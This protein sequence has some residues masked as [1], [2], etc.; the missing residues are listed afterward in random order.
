MTPA[1]PTRRTA[2]LASASSLLLAACGKGSGSDTGNSTVRA[3]N[4][5]NDLTSLDLYLGGAKAFGNVGIG[6][7]ASYGTFTAG[8]NTLNVNSTGNTTTLFTGSYTLS[9][10]AHYTA[11]V[12]GPQSSLRVS[13]LPEDE[14]TTAIASGNTR[15]R[16]FN[17]TTETGS[18]DVYFTA[19]DADLGASTPTQGALTTGALAGFK[20]IPSGTYRLRVTGVGNP[21]DVRLDIAAVTLAAGQ[22]QTLVI[23]A[24][25]GGVLV[26][27]TLI[28]QQGNATAL[29]NTKAR[30]RV[31]ASVDSAGVVAATVGGTVLAG[32]LLSPAVG[33]YTLVD[34]GTAISTTLRINGSIVVAG[35]MAYTAGADYTLLVYGQAGAGQYTAINDDNRLPLS[36]TRTKIRLVNGVANLDPLTM[37]VD[38]GAVSASSNVVAGTASA[39]SQIGS[40]AGAQIEVDSP[41]LGPVYLTTRT[42]GDVLA[43]QGVYTVFILSG[44]STPTGTLRNERP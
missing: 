1:F 21:N 5:S 10:D 44:K 42:N 17:A 38:Y 3:L 32:G 18:M 6:V 35:P 34:A 20:E 43:S 11:I 22:Y 4:L 30:V 27:G 26:N 13:T 29:T 41:T 2:L 16:M 39:Y 19:S 9:K 33:Q 25:A 15:V 14:D 12:W 8:S 7:M 37:L 23:T 28:Q 31:I 24:G 36:T 40:N